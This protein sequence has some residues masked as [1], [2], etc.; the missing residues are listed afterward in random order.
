[1]IV[2]PM[3]IQ[4]YDQVYI[5]ISTSKVKLHH[6]VL[7]RF[8]LKE[9][10]ITLNIVKIGV[11]VYHPNAHQKIWS[12]FNFEKFVKSETPSCSFTKVGFKGGENT[13]N[14][15][16]VVVHARLSNGHPNLW[17]NFNCKK[18]FKS[19]TSSC[20]FTRVQLKA[21]PNSSKDCKI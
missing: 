6:R 21:G 10:K 5:L 3:G 14:V 17:S 20:I 12:N 2:Y 13:R 19:E 9:L 4:I 18:I 1:M 16:K 11:H 7:L 8:G 15:M